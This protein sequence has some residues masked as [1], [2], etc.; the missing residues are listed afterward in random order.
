MTNDNKAL[1]SPDK[2]WVGMTSEIIMNSISIQRSIQR[3]TAA[4]LLF[5]I[6]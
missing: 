2:V 6:A 3:E 5:V 4:L 1:R